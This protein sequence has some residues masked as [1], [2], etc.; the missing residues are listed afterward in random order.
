[1]AITGRHRT[2]VISEW[3]NINA[4]DSETTFVS[5]LKEAFASK[6]PMPALV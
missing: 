1:M 6:K 5:M 4:K 2:P 3:C